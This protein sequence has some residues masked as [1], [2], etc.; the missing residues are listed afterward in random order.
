MPDD[1]E[2]ESYR[3]TLD[4]DRFEV[5]DMAY[6]HRDGKPVVDRAIL[7][8]MNL[9]Q[10]YFAANAGRPPLALAMPDASSSRPR[11]FTVDSQCYSDKKGYYDGWKVSGVPPKITVTPS[12]DFDTPDRKVYHGHI[13]NGVIGPG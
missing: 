3:G 10:H 12:V 11:Y 13:T 2:Y 7:A 9:T 8:K 6:I 1:Y 5:G 4:F